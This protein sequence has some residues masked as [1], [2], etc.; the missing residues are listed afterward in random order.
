MIPLRDRNPS[1]TF[2][3][4][5]LALIGLNLLVFLVEL[6]LPPAELRDF[7]GRLALVPARYSAGP[8][9]GFAAWL[10][11]LLTSMFLHA[12]W[13][14]LISNMWVLWLFG[15]NV[16]D[17]MGRLRFLLFYLLSG[18][19]AGVLHVLFSLSS[20]DPTV[21]ASGAVAGVMG[22]YVLLYPSARIVTLVPVLIIPLFVNLPAWIFI[23]FW[24]VTQLFSGFSSISGVGAQEGIAWWAHVG[25]FVFGA[26]ALPLFRRRDRRLPRGAYGR[27]GPPDLPWR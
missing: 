24:F 19:A 10:Q 17:R 4:V 2:P 14:H 13:L 21:G 5:T 18:I 6:S 20:A 27:R 1:L 25:G 15:D 9:S 8:A 3:F 26:L 16:E 7:F 11:P 22:A 12:G 23:G